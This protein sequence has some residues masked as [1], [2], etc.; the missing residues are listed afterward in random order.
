MN[1]TH[2][3]PTD[4][5]TAG[6]P[7]RRAVRRSERPTGHRVC[8]GPQGNDRRSEAPSHAQACHAWNGNP[9]HYQREAAH[10]LTVEGR[11]PT[12]WS[13]ITPRCDTP[14]CLEPDHLTVR[15]PVRLAYPHGLCIYCGRSGHTRD[16]L[17]PRNWT[18]DARRRFVVTVPCCGT[19]NSLLSDT[20]TWSITERRAIAHTRIRKHYQR[21]LRTK[22]FTPTELAQF[23]RTLRAHVE[24]AIAKKAE[25]LR[26]LD[27]P[28]DPTYDARALQ[29]SGIEDP[30][31]LGLILPEDHTI[32][33]TPA[34]P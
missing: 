16:H 11:E 26:M 7:P 32:H 6:R 15:T 13:W 24:D 34:T 10:T 21:A 4:S 5:A 17:L 19:C 31:A 3:I 27:F 14:N 29:H 30:W 23:G 22:D 18:G 9:R 20:L 8:A 28:T 1:H 12:P 33:L 25:V 2:V